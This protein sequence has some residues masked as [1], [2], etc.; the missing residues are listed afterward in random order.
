M[1]I[2]PILKGRYNVYVSYC[3]FAL[4]AKSPHRKFFCW[5]LMNI[6]VLLTSCGEYGYCVYIGA[7]QKCTKVFWSIRCSVAVFIVAFCSREVPLSTT[8]TDNGVFCN[9]QT[10]LL[11]VNVS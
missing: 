10:V 3:A 7:L 4:K 2:I 6:V 5:L 9:S 11:L 1:V 8:A